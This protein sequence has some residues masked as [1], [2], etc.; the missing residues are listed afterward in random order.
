MA[1]VKNYLQPDWNIVTTSNGFSYKQMEEAVRTVKMVPWAPTPDKHSEWVQLGG[2]GLCNNMAKSPVFEMKGLSS[3]FSHFCY[4]VNEFPYY[5]ITCVLLFV[6]LIISD[7]LSLTKFFSCP[8]RGSWME[9]RFS[10]YGNLGNDLQTSGRFAVIS[11]YVVSNFCVQNEVCFCL[12]VS[13]LGGGDVAYASFWWRLLD[14]YMSAKQFWQLTPTNCQ[15]SEQYIHMLYIMCQNNGRCW[16]V[17]AR[18]IFCFLS[19]GISIIYM[20]LF[21]TKHG[22]LS[23]WHIILYIYM[24]AWKWHL[25]FAHSSQGIKST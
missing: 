18:C 5:V 17:T 1:F 22:I 24:Y 13:V 16:C 20:A 2:Q 19:L 23:F 6:Q 11:C 3:W 8:V 12:S 14:K 9:A 10:F 7:H 15:A 4:C 25:F 21:W